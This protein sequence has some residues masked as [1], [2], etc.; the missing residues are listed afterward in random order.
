MIVVNEQRF[1]YRIYFLI[2]MK[3]RSYAVTGLV[4]IVAAASI[5]C[6]REDTSRASQKSIGK[7]DAIDLL[8]QQE[9]YPKTMQESRISYYE[10]T[11]NG[12]RTQDGTV[13]SK[14][15][16]DFFKILNPSMTPEQIAKKLEEQD[17]ITKDAVHNAWLEFGKGKWNLYLP[18]LT[19]RKY[20]N[21][22]L[23]YDNLSHLKRGLSNKITTLKQEL[24]P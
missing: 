17:D 14:G 20:N 16:T 12:I 15:F 24:K 22:G 19:E 9:Q 8:I 7:R 5:A 2:A 6:G 4:V 21:S 18:E 23:T 13:I 10:Y 3:F 1:K 11:L